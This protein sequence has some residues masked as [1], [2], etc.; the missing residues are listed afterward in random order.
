M[1]IFYLDEISRALQLL[2]SFNKKMLHKPILTNKI[3]ISLKN[4]TLYEIHFINNTKTYN[5][6]NFWKK[7]GK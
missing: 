3:E 4:A 6:V 7:E 2:F 5:I 1:I